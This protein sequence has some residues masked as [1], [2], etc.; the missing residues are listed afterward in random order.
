MLWAQGIPDLFEIEPFLDV[1]HRKELWA[2]ITADTV[3][4][5][6]VRPLAL[7]AKVTRSPTTIVEDG[8]NHRIFLSESL[9]IVLVSKKYMD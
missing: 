3:Y 2:G 4:L 1:A 7:L 8:T 5:F 9:V 6:S